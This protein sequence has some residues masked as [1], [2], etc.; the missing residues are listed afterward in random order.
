MQKWLILIINWMMTLIIRSV[1][2]KLINILLY[3]SLTIY[4]VWVKIVNEYDQ[5]IPQSQTADKPIAT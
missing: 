3:H 2:Q 1:S 5:V 4:K